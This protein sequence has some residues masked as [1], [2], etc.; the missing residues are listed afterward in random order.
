MLGLKVCMSE[1]PKNL[2]LFNMIHIFEPMKR[3]IYEPDISLISLM[4]N[5]A[6]TLIILVV[7]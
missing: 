1:G 2:G 5:Y 4:L 6:K 7:T 3:H